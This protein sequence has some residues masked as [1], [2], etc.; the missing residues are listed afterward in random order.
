MKGAALAG[1]G[2]VGKLIGAQVNTM[3]PANMNP[4]VQIPG[5]AAGVK[6]GSFAVATAVGAFAPEGKGLLT[7]VI[8]G[9]AA[10]M[11]AAS[12]PI[13]SS[14]AANQGMRTPTLGNLG[15]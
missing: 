2:I 1:G 3:I 11:G 9:V 6:V 7:Q 5:T 8:H 14:N 12:D 15:V 13:F 4:V 10:G